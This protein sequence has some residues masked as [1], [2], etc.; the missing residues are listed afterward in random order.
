LIIELSCRCV[1][2]PFNRP[3]P[4]SRAF[5]NVSSGVSSVLRSQRCLLECQ[6]RLS[7][8]TRSLLRHNYSSH[9]SYKRSWPA[10]T[11]RC[12]RAADTKA[13]SRPGRADG[14]VYFFAIVPISSH[15][16]SHLGAVRINCQ[17]PFIAH[18]Y[19]GSL[20][21]EQG[22]HESCARGCG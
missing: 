7:L 9:W 21:L 14:Q 20:S 5:P 11:A 15:A 22:V 18:S 4:S 3:Y 12:M 16:I 1:V 13:P 19:L 17:N 2:S 8:H 6:R 10:R